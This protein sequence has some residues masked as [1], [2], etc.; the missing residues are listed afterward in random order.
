MSVHC[1][2]VQVPFHP[3]TTGLMPVHL[4]WPSL[5]PFRLPP[6]GLTVLHPQQLPHPGLCPS[7]RVT[8]DGNW[9]RGTQLGEHHYCGRGRGGAASPEVGRA[10]GRAWGHHGS[11]EGQCA[12]AWAVPFLAL[13][14]GHN[15]IKTAPLF[16]GPLRTPLPLL[17]QL[18]REDPRAPARGTG[19][20]GGW[21]P[22]RRQAEDTARRPQHGPTLPPGLPPG[23]HH[24][25]Q[26]EGPGNGQTG[27]AAPCLLHP[28]PAA[29]AP[30]PRGR[31]R[32]QPWP[33]QGGEW[34][35]PSPG[36]GPL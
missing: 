30:G 19:D 7:P 15:K 27:E 33:W 13:L 12:A 2:A 28:L 16:K 11:G 35:S 20:G 21:V 18:G 6:E 9:G 31:L 14:C 8:S 4:M 24:T 36:S 29:S 23:P 17:G 10:L 25:P 3:I 5:H 34:P 26:R 32:L 22:T 1:L